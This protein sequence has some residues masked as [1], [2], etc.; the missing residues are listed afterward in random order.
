MPLV[1]DKDRGPTCPRCKRTVIKLV[2]L[3]DDGKSR[4]TCID[5]KREIKRSDPN[6]DYR[7]ANLY[8][9]E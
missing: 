3:T 7:K 6:R 5:C 1:D 2:S 8:L 9:D 4:K